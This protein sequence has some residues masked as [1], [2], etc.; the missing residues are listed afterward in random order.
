MGLNIYL[1]MLKDEP[2]SLKQSAHDL[3]EAAEN[4]LI[5]LGA[6]A[7]QHPDASVIKAVAHW[8]AQTTGCKL[9]VLA[10]A[11]SVAGHV[12]G[13][14]PGAG[15][16]NI[17]EMLSTPAKGFMLLGSEPP[18]DCIDGKS[19]AAA[20]KKIRVCRFNECV[21]QRHHEKLF[22]CAVTDC[23]IYRISRDLY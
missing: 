8:I 20:M 12:A 22:R 17:Q 7:L 15:G 11:N 6:L 21:L 5:I 10:P 13:C 9:A 14:L 16:K 4:G 18:L 3:I 23:R 1:K 19:A 2:Y